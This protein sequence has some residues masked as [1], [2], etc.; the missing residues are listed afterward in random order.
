[1]VGMISKAADNVI[2]KTTKQRDFEDGVD[3][4]FKV[5]L[6]DVTDPHSGDVRQVPALS[7]RSDVEMPTVTHKDYILQSLERDG[8]TLRADLF[9]AFKDR[10]TIKSKDGFKTALSRLRKSKQIEEVDGY[11]QLLD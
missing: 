1:M 8:R 7:Y 6:V 4:E 10:F 3:F 2:L 5:N 9:A 11:V